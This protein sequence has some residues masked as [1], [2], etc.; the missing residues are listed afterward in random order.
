M[1]K[2]LTSKTVAYAPIVVRSWSP[3]ALQ[4]Q[5]HKVADAARENSCA[6]PYLPHPF[7]L[8]KDASGRSRILMS[9]RVDEL[10]AEGHSVQDLGV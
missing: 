9:I 10:E 8:T 3:P 4:R 5:D 2:R 1:R 6:Y 7:Q